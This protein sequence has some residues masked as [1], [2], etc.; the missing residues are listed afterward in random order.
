[1]IKATNNAAMKGM[2][3]I[4]ALLLSFG[5]ANAQDKTLFF[6]EYIEGSGNNKALEIFNPTDAAVDLGEYLVLGNYNGNPINDT[7]RFEAGTMLESMGTFVIV[8]A[9]ADSVL[10][11]AADTL[12]TYGNPYT[13]A[14]NGDDARGLYHVSGTDTVLLDMFGAYDEDPGSAWDVAG[15]SGGTGEHTLVRKSQFM[16]GNAVP[17][18][19]FGTDE[20]SS[21]WI[22]FDQNDFSNIGTHTV[23]EADF[24]IR[25]FN[26]YRTPLTEVTNE[27]IQAH[28]LNGETKNFT[29]VVVSYPKSSGLATPTDN[30]GDGI[31]DVISRIHVFVT[32]T[33][34]VSMGREGMS[35]QLVESDY[36]VLEGFTRGDVIDITGTLSFFNSTAQ[37]TVEAATLVGNVNSAPELAAYGSLLSPW[38]VTADELNI[39]N[40]DGTHEINAGNYWKYNGAYVKLSGATVSN[41][42]TGDRPNWAVSSNG[43][44]IYTYDTSLRYRNDRVAYLP[45]YNYRHG[46]DPT[47]EPPSPGAIVD[48]S[49]FINL[50]GDDP[51]GNVTAGSQAFSINPMEDGVLW[52]NGTRY[53]TGDDLGG[54][55]FT[56]PNDLVVIGLPPVFS[57]V[58]QSDS[59]VTS[60]DDVTVSAT[61][62]GVEGATIASAN[63]IY[64]S[65]GV[66]DTLAMTAAGDVYSATI[67]AQPNFSA[68]SFYIEATDSEGLTG[69]EPIAGSFGYFVQD[70]AINTIELVQKTADGGPGASPLFGSGK[71]SMDITGLIVSDNA[72]G[73]IILQDTAAAW[74]GIFLEQTS[75][76]QALVRGDEVTIT[77]ASVHEAAVASNSLTLTQ[78]VDVEMTLVSQGNDIE[79]VI[80][81]LKTDSIGVWTVSGELEPYEG[82]VV[83]FEDVE[84]TDRGAYG[85]YTLQNTDA[86]S[87]TGAIFNEDIRSDSE[88][89]SVGVP[90][91]FNHSLRAGVVMDAYAVVAASFG[92]PKFHPRDAADF[93]TESG[94][95]FTPVLDFPLISPEDGVTVEVTGDV[96]A[97]WTATEDFDGQDVTYEW[98]LYSADTTAVVATIPSNNNG[99]DAVVT[100]PGLD[101][102]ALL[103][104]AG[105]NVGESATFVWNVRV[106]DGLDTLDVHGPYDNFGDDFMPIYRTI[107]LTRGV[108]NSNEVVNGVPETFS[109]E[110]NYPNPFNPTTNI[111][112]ALPQASKVSLTVYDMLGRKVATL[113]NGQQMQAANHTVQFDASALASG[114]YIYRIEAGNFISTRKMMLIK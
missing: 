55:T 103:A 79:T 105:L 25:D 2:L 32:D 92:A 50:V 19:S 70:G 13:T 12:I 37:V 111:R 18:A 24:T 91:D 52:L 98:V 48:L 57:E 46:D 64:S 58:S 95:A 6:S 67:P 31:I 40:E 85:E 61:I 9:D 71:L 23:A 100:I 41:V 10:K 45:T 81:V 110:Q 38:E 27:T 90:Y 65:N 35:I 43:S 87:E 36:T 96:E 39:L 75:A 17:K 102:D 114:M 59:S 69:R 15:V 44:R 68:V 99:E 66:A 80:P 89:G 86:T 77:A 5:A 76:T 83:K 20:V 1:M 28:P 30:D 11:A 29:A 104:G 47:F 72:D 112:F 42:S 82:M 16:S 113:L 49:G 7:L 94:N 56:W 60:S 109:L 34:A 78:L 14:F 107:T 62:V 63:L 51:D 97:T 74:G 84:L 93:I 26:Y 108:V 53:V 8:N 88:I 33:N 4:F 101:V 54:T 73:V 22:V 3:A 106:S 21:E